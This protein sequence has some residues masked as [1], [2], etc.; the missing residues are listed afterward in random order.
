MPGMAECYSSLGYNGALAPE[1]AFPKAR[2]AASRAL[3][4][5]STLADAHRALAYQLLFG[6]WDFVGADREYA[7]AVELDPSDAYALW[8]RGMYLAAMNRSNEAIAEQI[9]QATSTTARSGRIAD[10][11][12]A[13]VSTQPGC[14][15][16]SSGSPA[17]RYI[18]TG[19]EGPS[20]SISR[21]QPS[22]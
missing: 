7:R 9:R 4:L 22:H 19:M 3:E 21:W 13:S 8:L 11:W 10:S 1:I 17:W 15:V 6:E 16:S 2:A 18:R 20:D 5:D 14:W 12:S